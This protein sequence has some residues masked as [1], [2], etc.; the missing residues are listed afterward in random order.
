MSYEGA[1]LGG[2]LLPEEQFIQIMT[3]LLDKESNNIL[4]H[5]DSVLY[6]KT[7]K[8][9]FVNWNKF[10][11]EYLKNPKTSLL[12]IINF[13]NRNKSQRW[14]FAD[15]ENAVTESG[16]ID[17]TKINEDL[18]QSYYSEVLAK[19]LSDMFKAV[20]Q[21]LT[22]AEHKELYS[23]RYSQVKK[24]LA[25]EKWGD[26]NY[27]YENV[28]YGSG[29]LGDAQKRG[30]I[31]D[32]FL[33]HLGKLHRNLYS[34]SE[35]FYSFLSSVTDFSPDIRKEENA[36]EKFGFLQLLIN[37]LNNIGWQTGGDLIVT[38]AHGRVVANIQLKTSYKEGESIGQIHTDKLKNDLLLLKQDI[39]MHNPEA[40]QNFYKLLKTSSVAEEL[41]DA[42]IK[43]SFD[44][45]KE[46]LGLTK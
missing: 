27:T 16:K 12:A 33:N 18:K 42:A 35:E 26:K 10:Q 41:G 21:K 32:A 31:A 38:D 36:Y 11:N 14:V 43:T 46:E 4:Q 22:Y 3:Q 15:E 2:Y 13:S 25:Q 20:R 5:I 9:A 44:L 28:I 6:A 1:M 23:S 17:I 45:V 29:S 7:V 40:S 24:K 30:K 8:E 19:H 37:S 39:L 34:T